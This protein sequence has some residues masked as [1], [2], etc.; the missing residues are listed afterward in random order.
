MDA[1]NIKGLTMVGGKAISSDMDMEDLLQETNVGKKLGAKTNKIVI[2]LILA[3]MMSIPVFSVDTFLLSEDEYSGALFSL[4]NRFSGV[5]ITTIGAEPPD[6]MPNTSLTAYEFEVPA[7]FNAAWNNVVF[8]YANRRVPLLYMSAYLDV[9]N[10]IYKVKND[11]GD[12]NYASYLRSLEKQIVSY[13][14]IAWADQEKVKYSIIAYWDKRQDAILDGILGIMRTIFVCFILASAS[15]QMGNDAENL[16]ITPI[17]TMIN[18]VKRIAKNP[19]EAAQIEESD[20]LAWEE[21]AMKDKKVVALTKEK[22][23][24]ET[25]MLESIIVKIGALL[26]LG[27]GEAGSVIIA[28]NMAKSGGVDP[29]LPG[30]KMFAVF[31]F[32]DIRNFADVTEILQIDVMMFVNEVADI[33]HNIVDDYSGAPNKNIGD[34]FLLI[35]KIPNDEIRTDEEENLIMKGGPKT[36]A[37]ADMS[38]F[39]F[40]KIIATINKSKKLAKYRDHEGLNKRMPGYRIRMGFGL[41][42]G[43]GIEGAIGSKFKIDASYLSPN[44]NMAARLEAATK[45]FGVTLLISGGVY[46]FCSDAYKKVLRHLDRVTVKG[47]I[48]PI[49][50]YTID[51]DAESLPLDSKEKE[52]MTGIEKRKMGVKRK[53]DRDTRRERIFSQKLTTSRL[54]DTDTDYQE[55]RKPF[56]QAFYVRWENALQ[57]YLEGQWEMAK[58]ILEETLN[59]T[60][61]RTDGPSQTLLGVINDHNGSAPSDWKGFRELTEK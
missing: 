14:Y 10:T 29:M 20:A 17:E 31:G 44:V 21:L 61:G 32:C 42:I 56:K 48:Q 46:R 5:K 33:V 34:A 6:N 28:E 52:N 26:A 18:K 39:A 30:Q 40:L 15:I 43:W 25:S 38:I 59:M 11:Y 60:P 50:F 47:S 49:D 22:A 3:I 51:T 36:Q 19:L 54:L 41:H 23:K 37:I 4:A 27:F 1:S 9:Y 55:M 12:I 57:L 53:S 35:W 2:T 8:H 16:V 58:P 45:Q 7:I 13:D 24:F